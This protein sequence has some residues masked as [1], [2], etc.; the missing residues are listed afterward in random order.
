MNFLI[1]G[2]S[3]TWGAWDLEGGGWANRLKNFIDKKTVESNFNKYR[4]VYSLGV[5]GNTSD[6]LLKRFENELVVRL[7]K[8]T[9]NLVL[10]LI[11]ANDSQFLLNDNSNRVS[12]E[13]FRKNINEI[14]NIA[15]KQNVKIMLVGLFPVDDEKTKEKEEGQ[16]TIYKLD[17]I[18]KYNKLIQKIAEENKIEF[19]DIFQEI[20]NRDYKSLLEDGLHPNSEGHRIIFETVKNYLVENNFL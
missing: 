9:D 15:L 2:D 3:L 10:V 11:G 17:Q 12:P 14:I 13:K 8:N 20:I 18:E 1:F 16:D 5:S 6:D 4:Y 7:D 19:I